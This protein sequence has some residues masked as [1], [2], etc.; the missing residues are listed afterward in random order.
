MTISEQIIQVI[1]ALCEKFGIAVNWTSDNVIPYLEILGKKLIS[2]EIF[3]SIFWLVLMPSLSIASIIMYK[4]FYPV[5]IEGLKRDNEGFNIGW[6]V[7]TPFCLIGF[8]GLNLGTFMVVA[9]QALDIIK[10]LTFPEMYI[11]EYISAL[12]Q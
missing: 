11:F 9:K 6:H 3:S 7:A 5:F 10:C 2:Y 8:A 4:K 12:L 1:N